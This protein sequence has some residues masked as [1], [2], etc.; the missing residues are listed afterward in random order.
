LADFIRYSAKRLAP[1]RAAPDI[2]FAGWQ[3]VA[4]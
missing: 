1:Q 4:E 2:P 3:E